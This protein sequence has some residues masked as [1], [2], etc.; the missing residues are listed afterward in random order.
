LRPLPDSQ[1]KNN[2]FKLSLTK[3]RNYCCNFHPNIDVDEK[4]VMKNESNF[5][6]LNCHSQHFFSFYQEK[7][8]EKSSFFASRNFHTRNLLIII[9][10]FTKNLKQILFSQYIFL[11]LTFN[12]HC[13]QLVIIRQRIRPWYLNDDRSLASIPASCRGINKKK[14]VDEIWTKNSEHLGYDWLESIVVTV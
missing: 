12:S 6:K 1:E 5:P 14:T 2:Y 11:P 10:F 9:L 7:A 8:D 3:S 13:C 4:I